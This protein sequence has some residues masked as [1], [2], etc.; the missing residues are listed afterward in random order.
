MV[1]AFMATRFAQNTV[2]ANQI[3][4]EVPKLG[5]FMDGVERDVLAYMSCPKRHR[6]K[7][8]SMNPI[9]R[10]Y[11]K[12]KR[13]TEVDSIFRTDETIVRLVGTSFLEHNDARVVQ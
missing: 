5:T 4:S 8:P 11:G 10:L 7:L 13:R 12:V 2:E 6:A 3:M 1:S 9:E